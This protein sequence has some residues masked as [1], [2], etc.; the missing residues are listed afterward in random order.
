[1]FCLKK[2][3][4]PQYGQTLGQHVIPSIAHN[5]HP[6]MEAPN[7]NGIAIRQLT[8]KAK[9]AKSKHPFARLGES[10]PCLQTGQKYSPLPAAQL[11]A[12]LPCGASGLCSL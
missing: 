2:F 7:V 4:E 11:L 3:F 5:T 9:S 12:L 1:M 8:N 10:N 6:A